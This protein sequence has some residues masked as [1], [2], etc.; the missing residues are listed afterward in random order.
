LPVIQEPIIPIVLAIGGVFTPVLAKHLSLVDTL[1]VGVEHMQRNFEPMRK[2]VEAWK[3]TRLPDETAKLVIYRAFVGGELNSPPQPVTD[4][5]KSGSPVKFPRGARE[6]SCA[7]LPLS[8]SG[9]KNS[10]LVL[11]SPHKRKTGTR[12]RAHR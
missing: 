9:R 10:M 6:K 7:P 5:R 1:T 12:Y 11:K 8:L 2:Q 3:G 4:N